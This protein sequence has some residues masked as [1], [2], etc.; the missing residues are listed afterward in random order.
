MRGASASVEASGGPDRATRP[1]RRRSVFLSSGS[2]DMALAS[3]LER[4]LTA[5]GLDVRSDRDLEPGVPDANPVDVTGADRRFAGIFLCCCGKRRR[6]RAHAV[7]L[8]TTSES[9]ECALVPSPGD[10]AAAERSTSSCA[11]RAALIASAS[12]RPVEPSIS[13]NRNVTTPEGGPPADT[14]TGCHTKPTSTQQTA[15]DFRDARKS[16]I[17]RQRS[18]LLGPGRFGRMRR[19]PWRRWSSFHPCG[20]AIR[21]SP[22]RGR[23]GGGR[24]RR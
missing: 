24:S 6:K 8:R 16:S 20:R 17:K 15:T 11:N 19:S 5:H 1:D 3:E 18:V 12:H 14:R 2:A 13:V 21:R 10:P 4:S 23:R 9:P 7:L 22:R